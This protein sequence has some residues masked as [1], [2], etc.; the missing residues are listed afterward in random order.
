MTRLV[1]SV[2]SIRVALLASSAAS[3]ASVLSSP[4]GIKQGEE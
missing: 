3:D 4:R 1:P 2:V